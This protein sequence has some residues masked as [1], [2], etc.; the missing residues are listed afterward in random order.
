MHYTDKQRY[1][2]WLSSVS[3][4]GSKRFFELLNRYQSPKEVFCGDLKGALFLGEK[5]LGNLNKAR[6]S[7]YMETLF[8]RLDHYRVNAITPLSEEY[9]KRLL[10]IYDPPP[11][12]YIKGKLNLNEGKPFAIVGSRRCSRE[13]QKSAFEFAKQLANSGVTIVSGLAYGI[14]TCAHEGCLEGKGRTVAV[15][16]S[17]VE[18]AYPAQNQLLYEK[19]LDNGGS[20]ISEYLPGVQPF[21]GNFPA[22]NRIISGMCDG[23]LIVEAGDKSGAMITAGYAADQGKELYAIPGSIYAPQS[24][25]TNRLIRDGAGVAL[26]PQDIMEGMR[27]GEISPVDFKPKAKNVELNADESLVFSALNEGERS[28]DE[29]TMITALSSARLNSLLTTLELKG[30]I[31]KVPGNLYRALYK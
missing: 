8:R 22:R 28:Y 25:S 11:V 12:L 3:G 9:P 4:I 24:E 31:E 6:S 16:G 23:V 30:I 26:S 15:L 27:W 18:R 10:D 1:W 20:I 5:V 7:Q 14:D 13:G 29:L 19:I 17:G 21:S 2:I